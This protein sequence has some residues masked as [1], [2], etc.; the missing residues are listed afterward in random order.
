MEFKTYKIDWYCIS[1]NCHQKT[2]LQSCA[3]HMHHS[4]KPI[5]W[6]VDFIMCDCFLAQII[7]KSAYKDYIQPIFQLLMLYTIM[8]QYHSDC[9]ANQSS[10]LKCCENRVE[11][12]SFFWKLHMTWAA[13][14]TELK[15]FTQPMN[16]Y[17]F[18][19]S[20]WAQFQKVE[21]CNISQLIL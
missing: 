18:N 19:D 3:H 13:A 17:L 7:E 9:K 20:R 8:G 5:N 15:C 4:M 14:Q 16:Q 1:R 12:F 10:W 21:P 6:I 11:N 2:P